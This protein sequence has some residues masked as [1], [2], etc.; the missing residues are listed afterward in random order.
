MNSAA[1]IL[2]RDSGHS[3]SLS[4]TATGLL[5][6]LLVVVFVAIAV[7]SAILFIRY[8][9]SRQAP[10]LPLHNDEC[11]TPPSNRLTIKT[12]SPESI[13]V[14]DEK[15]ELSKSME[16]TPTSPVPEIRITFP[17][18]EDP[19]GRPVS[20]RVVVVH[21]GE[22]GGIG[23]EPLSNDSLPPYPASGNDRFQSLDIDRMGGLK[24]KP[25]PPQYS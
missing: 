19:T 10:L 21:I 15:R 4:R 6:A 17:E 1:P 22:Q 25:D 12:N 2:R 23:L 7:I 13:S 8:R 9:R 16:N 5:I 18:E 3:G 20:G 11:T 24:E 14:L